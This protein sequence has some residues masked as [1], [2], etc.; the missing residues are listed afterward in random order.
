MVGEGAGG[1]PGG[2]VPSGRIAA[3]STIGHA[4]L[5]WKASQLGGC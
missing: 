2:A 5:G 1:G 4:E 3:W